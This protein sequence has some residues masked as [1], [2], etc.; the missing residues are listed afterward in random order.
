LSPSLSSWRGR[1]CSSQLATA[2]PKSI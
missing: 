1:V 2:L